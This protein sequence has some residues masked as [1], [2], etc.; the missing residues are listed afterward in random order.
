ML[1]LSNI[2]YFHAFEIAVC[3]YVWC[4][5]W[6]MASIELNCEMALFS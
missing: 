3:V 1:I 4:T 6:Q 5:M 2:I